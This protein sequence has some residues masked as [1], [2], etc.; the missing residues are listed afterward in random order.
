M[1]AWRGDSSSAANGRTY[2]EPRREALRSCEFRST[3]AALGRG[4]RRA[5][6][7]LI[8]KWRRVTAT[9]RSVALC[10]P[11]SG[12][13]GPWPV[14]AWLVAAHSLTTRPPAPDRTLQNVPWLLL[15]FCPLPIF[16]RNV[17]VCVQTHWRPCAVLI[18][19]TR[20][21][22]CHRRFALLSN[23]SLIKTFPSI[24]LIKVIKDKANP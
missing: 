13:H 6:R 4:R 5:R 14:M 7:A 21:L 9:A 22:A 1:G 12:M 16:H 10:A 2:T 3:G 17:N 24:S 11:R 15:L 20:G 19:A 23:L 18:R 8:E